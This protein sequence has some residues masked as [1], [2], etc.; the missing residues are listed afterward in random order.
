MNRKNRKKTKLKTKPK[1][2]PK[3][4][5]IPPVEN[6]R[7]GAVVVTPISSD[8]GEHGKWQNMEKTRTT[9]KVIAVATVVIAFAAIVQGYELVIGSRDTHNLALAALAANRA[10]LAPN[11]MYLDSPLENGLPVQSVVKV[12]NVGREPA[13]GLVWKTTETGVPYIPDTGDDPIQTNRNSTCDG[14]E[15]KPPDGMVVY[16]AGANDSVNDLVPLDIQD[17]PDNRKLLQDAL[18]R[19]KSIVIDGCFAYRT[20]G[21]KHTSSF[22]FLL[23]DKPGQPSF[24]LNK[25]GHP[26]PN[27]RFNALPSGNEAD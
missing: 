17:S 2:Q 11:Y 22:R 23:R 24:V 12:V 3:P 16:P 15:P 9:D 25:D 5:P 8:H 1:P 10:W 19:T 13:L 7:D 18:N 26:V 4:P 6:A 20:G 27:W 14:L 21:G